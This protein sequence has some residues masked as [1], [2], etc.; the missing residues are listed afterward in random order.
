MQHTCVFLEI[1]NNK[2]IALTNNIR[3]MPDIYFTKCSLR[4]A[5][6]ESYRRREQR[7]TNRQTVC[8]RLHHTNRKCY[9]S[10]R[11]LISYHCSTEHRKEAREREEKRHGNILGIV[12]FLWIMNLFDKQKHS[13]DRIDRSMIV[14]EHRYYV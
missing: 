14:N 11:I 7:A 9:T 4:M 6:Q 8:S 13:Y 1:G 10:Q 12:V 5:E 3:C 2:L